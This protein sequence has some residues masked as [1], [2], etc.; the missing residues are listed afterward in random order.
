MKDSLRTEAT[1]KLLELISPYSVPFLPVATHK[2]VDSASSNV[3]GE[4]RKLPR[5]PGALNAELEQR[6]LRCIIPPSDV[7]PKDPV[8][9]EALLTTRSIGPLQQ[10]QA[11]LEDGSVHFV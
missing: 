4:L 5:K 3:Y 10:L 7:W 6:K 11:A 2:S 1:E 9:L 8:G